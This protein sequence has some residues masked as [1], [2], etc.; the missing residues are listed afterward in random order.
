MTAGQSAAQIVV[1]AGRNVFVAPVGSTA[2]AN[3]T[4]APAAAYIDIGHVTEDGVTIDAGGTTEDVRAWT[5][6]TPVRVM[7]TAREFNVSFGLLQWNQ[8]TLEV[9][10]E[11]GVVSGAGPYTY[12]FP[13][14]N[15]VLPEYA[16][17]IDWID[18]TGR[19]GR[20]FM[21]RVTRSDNTTTTLARTAPASLAIAFKKLASTPP[22][23]FTPD[24]AFGP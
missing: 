11:G 5:A 10:F 9:A 21:P 8:K 14:D 7:L 6:G 24:T 3:A 4:T 13:A 1:A 18:G 2:P 22:L 16:L 15:D 23:L 19:E 20:L 17:I 12:T